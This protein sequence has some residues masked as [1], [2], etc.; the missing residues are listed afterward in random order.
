LGGY[1]GIQH[2]LIPAPK[3]VIVDRLEDGTITTR[4]FQE[5]QTSAPMLQILGYSTPDNNLADLSVN[6]VSKTPKVSNLASV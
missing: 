3:H 4:L 5:E 1:G 2:C 6:D